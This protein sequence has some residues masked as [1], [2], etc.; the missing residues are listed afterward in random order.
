MSATD[1]TFLDQLAYLGGNISGNAAAAKI[2]YQDIEEFVISATL[3]M[4]DD[5]RVTHCFL[6]WLSFYGSLLS[7]SK[8]RRLLKEKPFDPSVFGAFLALLENHSLR[9]NQWSILE[10]FTK[11]TQNQLLFP[12]LPKPKG[13]LNP[14]FNKFGIIAHLLKADP[15]KFLIDSSFVLN[16]CPE[17]KFRASDL[18]PV[19]ADLQAFLKKQTP[20][21]LYEVAKA[22]HHFRAQ[23]YS[24]YRYL[25]HFGICDGSLLPKRNVV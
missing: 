7:P 5:V 21:T 20:K 8:I 17:I 3:H 24:H 11:R 19:P 6:S 16:E 2:E 25:S 1:P 23:I 13:P 18:D 9:K 10:P 14:Y 12:D 15:K 22:T 4:S